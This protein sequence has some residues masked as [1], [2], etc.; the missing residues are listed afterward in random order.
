MKEE[1]VHVMVRVRPLNKKELLEN[2]KNCITVDSDNAIT[3]NDLSNSNGTR[4]FTFD[5]VFTESHAQKVIYDHSAFP[6]VE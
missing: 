1:S 2:D 3:I 6:I 4:G 5:K